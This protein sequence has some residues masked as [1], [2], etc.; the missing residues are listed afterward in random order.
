[1][2]SIV[3]FILSLIGNNCPASSPV[4]DLSNIRTSVKADV[5]R[6]VFDITGE[7]EPAYYL[8]KDKDTINLTLEA[9]ISP[10]KEIELKKKLQNSKYIDSIKVLHLPAE[11]E[12]ILSMKLKAK[13]F[14]QFMALP[15]PSRVVIDISKNKI[16]E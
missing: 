13:T 15:N 9:S 4:N 2:L 1:M 7:N 14:E 11:G 16:G 6:I 3:V 12:L 10:S 8:K 5:Q